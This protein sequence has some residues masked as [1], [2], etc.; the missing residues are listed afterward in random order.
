MSGAFCG[1]TL[2]YTQPR[3]MVWA[4]WSPARSH[5]GGSRSGDILKIFTRNHCEM[6]AVRGYSA[7]LPIV[8]LREEKRTQKPFSPSTR[9]DVRHFFFLPTARMCTFFSPTAH[10][11][12]A[13]LQPTCPRELSLFRISHQI[14]AGLHQRNSYLKRQV[15]FVIT[16]LHKL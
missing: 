15:P 14:V 9:N 1:N 7:L 5:P 13:G 4:S 8:C 2:S 6:S 16:G 10:Q 11:T 12:V 3:A